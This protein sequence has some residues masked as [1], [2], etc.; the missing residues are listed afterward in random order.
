MNLFLVVWKLYGVP[1]KATSLI[2][3]FNR[4]EA[5]GIKASENH[6]IQIISAEVYKLEDV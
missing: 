2:Y 1:G 6:M 3:A 5:M 4:E